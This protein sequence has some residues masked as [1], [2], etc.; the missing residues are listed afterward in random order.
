MTEP[1]LTVVMSCYNQ[2]GTIAQ[3]IDS[4]LMQKTDFPVRLII[5]D[6]HSTKDGSVGII[7]DYAAKHPDRIVA[8]LNDANGRYLKNVLRAMAQTK[9]EYFTLLDADDYW[10]DPDYLSD[11]VR[12]LRA[13]ENFT[14]YFRNVAWDDGLGGK[15][16]QH[17]ESAPDFDMTFD[18]WVSGK[19]VF[20]QTTGAVF[21]NVVY[22][23]G[24]PP[25]I[26]A[27]VGTIH[28]RPYDGDVFRF[29]LHLN[30]GKAHFTNK[31]AGVYRVAPAGVFAGMPPA[32]RDMIQA[33]CFVDYCD[34]FGTARTSF[35]E[36]ALSCYRQAILSP[37]ARDL[38]EDA[39]FQ[40]C[41]ESVEGFCLPCGK[42]MREHLEKVARMPRLPRNGLLCYTYNDGQPELGYYAPKIMNIGD[43]VQS[44]AARQFLPAVDE[45]VDR[46]Q[47]GAYAGEPVNMIMNAWHRL[48]RK[49]RVFASQINPLMVAVHVNNPEDATE[50]TID[51]FKRHEPVGCR[52]FHTLEFLQAKGIKAYFSGC[53]TLT[54]GRTY[55]APE[56]ERTEDIYFV[57]YRLGEC[58]TIDET[59][60]PILNA[61]KRRTRC[62]YRTHYYPLSRDVQGG[63]REAEALVREY[64]RA[65]LVI[66]RNIH[67]ALPCLALGTPVVFVIPKFDPT[68]FRGL[69]EFFNYVGVDEKGKVISNVEADACGQVTNPSKHLAYAEFL[70]KI[71]SAFGGGAD[72]RGIAPEGSSASVPRVR[73]PEAESETGF[74]RRVFRKRKLGNRREVTVFGKFVFRYG[75]RGKSS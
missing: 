62:F 51:Y 9:S 5:T 18:D 4:V 50:E 29:L 11:A 69:M 24:I 6:D 7:R 55:R 15:G 63:L 20:P 13:H 53:L 30:E 52:D 57:D 8:L 34:Y 65:G 19:P 10:T 31:V 58:P 68:R 46:D 73:Y 64:A 22:K 72:F 1:L 74:W 48:W 71:A 66:T 32:K 67:C 47:L 38:A 70:E 16:V 75:S 39:E 41:C 40:A 21:R 56:T 28:E 17:E 2:A 42:A 59:L 44:L 26:A 49:C 60:Y 27:A 43:Y 37:S 25:K 23:N 61:R 36:R 14:I 35:A 12:F 45:Y 54:L 33:Q 3:A